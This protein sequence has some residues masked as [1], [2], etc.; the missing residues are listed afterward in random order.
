MPSDPDPA[1]YNDIFQASPGLNA[2]RLRLLRDEI[3]Q[4]LQ[5]T[6]FQM[7]D[8][9]NALDYIFMLKYNERFP[10]NDIT[11]PR[12]PRLWTSSPTT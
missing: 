1:T 7:M 6:Q 10:N 11:G 9:V 4:F 3:D 8:P 12:D 5:L 2:A